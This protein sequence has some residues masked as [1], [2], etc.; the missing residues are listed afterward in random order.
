MTTLLDTV[1]TYLQ[2]EDWEFYSEQENSLLRG[3]INGDA[4]TLNFVHAVIEDGEYNAVRIYTTVPF[5]VPEPR[6]PAV[7]KFLTRLNEQFISSNFEL[8]CGN[9][10]VR[11]KT[12]LDLM[13]GTL[14]QAMLMH[15]FIVNLQ[16]TN[17][18]LQAIMGV[19]FGGMEPATVLV[20]L[21]GADEARQ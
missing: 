3:S 14:T 4:G 17:N 21:E 11:Y 7:A 18:Y 13:D 8:D 6:R 16:T 2:N 10:Q 20:M 19:A 1:T 5:N 12:T 9:G 15:I